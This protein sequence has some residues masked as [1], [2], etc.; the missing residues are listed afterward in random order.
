MNP[1]YKSKWNINRK[2]VIHVGGHH[3]QELSEYYSDSD[4]KQIV[5]FEANPLMHDVL[6]ANINSTPKPPHIQSIASYPVGLGAESKEV[7]FHI[8]SN[9]QSSSVLVPHLH[10]Q[11]YP[12]I[13]FNEIKKIN[14]KTLDSFELHGFDFLHMD[15]QGYELEVLKGAENTLK[16]IKWIFCEVNNAPLYE[17]CAMIGDLDVYLANRGFSRQ[18]TEWDSSSCGTWGD[19]I[20]TRNN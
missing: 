13:T 17:E 3:G 12:G 7:D 20:Y 10:L 11:Q 8:A 18:D 9:G 15:V 16:Q 4:I 2:G 14:I 1:T 6:V 5:F 19:A